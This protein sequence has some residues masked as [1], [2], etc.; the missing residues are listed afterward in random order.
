MPVEE[1]RGRRR[2]RRAARREGAGRRRRPRRPLGRRRV[3]AHRRD[4]AGREGAGR[5]GHRRDDEQ[6]RRAS[7]SGR[8]RWAPTRRWPRSSGWSRRRRARRRRSS[9]SP[10]A[11]PAIFVPAV[12]GIAAADVRRLARVRPGAGASRSRMLELRRGAD[13]RLPVRARPGHADGDH[14]RH[15]QGRR[16]RHPDPG[17]EALETAHELHARSCSTRPAR[18]PRASRGHRRRALGRAAS[19]RRTSCC[20]LAAA[21]ERGSEHPLGEAIVAARTERGLDARRAAELRRPSPATASRPAS[22]AARVL[23]GNAA[24]MASAGVALDGARSGGRA[25]WPVE[26]KTP[27][28]VAVD[29]RVGGL[30]A[31]ADTLKPTLGRGR[32]R[33]A[34]ARARGRR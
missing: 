5:R 10:T 24:L 32:R 1:V 14:G 7:A 11:S 9:A 6:D 27:M 21:A 19:S 30:I 31:V 34:P 17:G 4:P 2:R 23:L 25:R 12:I 28:F 33:P 13:H 29:G 18:S 22:T 26:G 3:D 20:A 16:E 8:P 15:G